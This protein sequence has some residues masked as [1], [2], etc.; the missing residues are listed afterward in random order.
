MKRFSKANQTKRKGK[1]IT[2]KRVMSATEQTLRE[3]NAKL[4]DIIR[5]LHVLARVQTSFMLGILTCELIE[6]GSENCAFERADRM[7]KS[8]MAEVTKLATQDV[9]GK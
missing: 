3:Q 5:E 7:L 1:M 6:N 2:V 9:V 4:R 8:T